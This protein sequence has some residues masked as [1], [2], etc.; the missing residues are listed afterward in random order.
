[1]TRGLLNRIHGGRA[2]VHNSPGTDLKMKAKMSVPHR[3]LLPCNGC[4][5]SGHRSTM[6]FK[7][8]S[9]SIS[10]DSMHNAFLGRY[11]VL[12]L[13][14]SYRLSSRATL[15]C[16]PN[17]LNTKTRQGYRWISMPF[18]L[19]GRSMGC[20]SQAMISWAKMFMRSWV[21]CSDL[22]MNSSVHITRRTAKCC[23]NCMVRL[24]RILVLYEFR[25]T[26]LVFVVPYH[27]ST[28]SLSLIWNYSSDLAAFCTRILSPSPFS[29]PSRLLTFDPCYRCRSPAFLVLRLLASL[30]S[31]YVR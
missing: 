8:N 30:S 23:G 5:T 19:A 27:P 16:P 31:K 20:P 1:M 18:L 6:M 14:R 13:D 22:K 2:V 3:T 24:V 28:I 4:R 21:V 12:A 17:I 9:H 29:L 7:S 11:Q 25:D 10:I 15:L 26:Y